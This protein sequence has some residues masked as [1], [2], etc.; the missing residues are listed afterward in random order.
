M[1]GARGRLAGASRRRRRG[2]RAPCAHTRLA[3]RPCPGVVRA[4]RRYYQ[5][6]VSF[7]KSA[8]DASLLALLWNKYWINTLSSSTLVTNSEYMNSQIRDLADKLEQAEGQLVQH[9]RSYYMGG[10][11]GLKTSA[12]KAEDSQLT[13]IC[14]DSSKVTKDHIQGLMSQIIKNA[15]FNA[16]ASGSMS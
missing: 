8:T 15:A 1:A 16:P 12:S 9:N 2:A 6:E 14:R 13:K 3:A 7:F 5:L 10:A 11:G 4:R